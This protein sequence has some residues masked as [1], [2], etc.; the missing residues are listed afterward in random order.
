MATTTLARP[1]RLRLVRNLNLV[2]HR[3]RLRMEARLILSSRE[4]QL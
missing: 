1:L 2:V 4:D 3:T